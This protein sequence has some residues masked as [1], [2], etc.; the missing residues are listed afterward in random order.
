[1][2][3]RIYMAGPCFT[4]AERTWNTEVVVSLRRR[5]DRPGQE[6]PFEWWLPQENVY[7]GWPASRI[8]G[9]LRDGLLM[10]YGIVANL[11]GPDGDSGTCWELGF[12]SG[13]G[14]ALPPIDLPKFWYRTDF[15][16]GG[17]SEDNVNLMMAMS[18]KRIDLP[19]LPKTANPAEYVADK[20]LAEVASFFPADGS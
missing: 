13:L 1:M 8:Y 14:Q 10:S 4:T 9:V 11:D 2:T 19:C 12:M 6:P 5:P 16:R 15:R 20:I 17:D 7:E 18:A 3:R